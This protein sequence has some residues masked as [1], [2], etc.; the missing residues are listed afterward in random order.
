MNNKQRL[1]IHEKVFHKLYLARLTSNNKKVVDILALI[2]TYCF[3]VNG[4]NGEKSQYEV[5][6]VM[7]D[8]LEKLNRL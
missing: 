8:Y 6:K 1:E 2:D 7:D 3:A 5:R 4:N